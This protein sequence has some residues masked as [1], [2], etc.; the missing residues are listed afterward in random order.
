MSFRFFNW[1]SVGQRSLGNL[2]ANCV[3]IFV[4]LVLK[5]FETLNSFK[6][7]Y[8]TYLSLLLRLFREAGIGIIIGIYFEYAYCVVI[9]FFFCLFQCEV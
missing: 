3:K 7:F 2:S 5:W 8:A 4:I 1:V 9:Y 6:Y